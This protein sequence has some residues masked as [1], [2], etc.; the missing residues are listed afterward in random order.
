MSEGRRG[1]RKSY[2]AFFFAATWIALALA[3]VFEV[4][5]LP[6]VLH[7]IIAALGLVAVVIAWRTPTDRG[8]GSH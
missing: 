7:A 2:A 6:I 4:G 3:I 5:T 1:I 8:E